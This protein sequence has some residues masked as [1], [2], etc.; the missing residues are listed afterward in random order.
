MPP[1]RSIKKSD[2]KPHKFK[3]RFA[4]SPSWFQRFTGIDVKSLVAR[5]LSEAYAAFCFWVIL[6][7]F[8]DAC[9]NIQRTLPIMPNY[10]PVELVTVN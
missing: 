2:S 8:S 7:M 9:T 3:V 6:V 4:P 10:A 5:L 1:R